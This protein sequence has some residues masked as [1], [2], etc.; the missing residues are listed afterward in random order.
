M[1]D[2]D[3]VL[4]DFFGT[5]VG[6]NPSRKE[7]G[8]DR[9][10]AVF[11][12]L[13]GTHGYDDFL[14]TWD[15]LFCA[16]ELRCEDDDSEFS[17]WDVTAAYFADALASSASPPATAPD[18]DE[19]VAVYLDEW[20]TGVSDIDGLAAM[21]DEVGRTCR[22]A[23]VTNTH[24]PDLVPAHLRR[25]GLDGAFEAVV[26]SVEVGWRK[27]HPVIYAAALDRVGLDADRC[28]F[29]GDTL[30]PDYVGPRTAGMAAR[31]I[32]PAGRHAATVPAAD[33]LASVLDLPATLP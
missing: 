17:M 21:L 19:F 6:Y 27:P 33:R 15:E 10:H 24:A 16:F 23:V 20:N 31:L 29:V 1:G 11:R 3:C 22:L 12:R 4:F 14:H 18:I 26:T 25:M 9:S 13:G 8:Y 32:D 30:E 5:L 7:Q 28:V 2:V